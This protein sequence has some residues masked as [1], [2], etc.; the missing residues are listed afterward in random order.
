MHFLPLTV[1]VIDT[2]RRFLC[3]HT[4]YGALCFVLLGKIEISTSGCTETSG[5]SSSR[6]NDKVVSRGPMS[7]FGG[8]GDFNA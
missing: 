4:G 2:Q 6:Q 1:S 5:Q 8:F 3:T 7:F